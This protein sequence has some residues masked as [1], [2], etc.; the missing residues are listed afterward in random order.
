MEPK[1]DWPMLNDG[2]TGGR[3]VEEFY[4][5]FEEMCGLALNGTGMAP[6]EMMVCLKR[7]LAGSRRKIYD[8]QVKQYRNTHNRHNV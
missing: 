4:E 7:C 3:D 1:L 8:N 6:R 2:H 5:R